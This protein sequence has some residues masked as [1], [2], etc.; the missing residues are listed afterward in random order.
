MLNGIKYGWNIDID[1]VIIME[2]KNIDI[3]AFN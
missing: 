1:I 2:N 3:S